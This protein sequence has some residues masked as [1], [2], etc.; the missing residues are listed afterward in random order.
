MAGSLIKMGGAA[1]DYHTFFKNYWIGKL[2]NE[3]LLIKLCK[4]VLSIMFQQIFTYMQLVM[5]LQITDTAIA[6]PAVKAINNGYS[7]NF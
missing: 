5:H 7:R 1:T 2:G 3:M 4:M 6:A